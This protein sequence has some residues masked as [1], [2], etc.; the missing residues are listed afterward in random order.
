MKETMGDRLKRARIAAD[1]RSATKGAERVGV[2]ASTYR[3]H[4]NGQNE[5]GSDD[6]EVYGRA[7]GVRAGWLLTGEPPMERGAALSPSIKL[8][9]S[10]DPDDHTPGGDFDPSEHSGVSTDRVYQTDVEGASPVVDTRAGAGPGS[11]ALPAVTQSGGVIYSED[12]VLGEILLPGYLQR[13]LSA[14]PAGRIHWI[15][16][17]GDSMEPT[18]KGGDHIAVDTTDASIAQGGMFVARNGDGE[19]IVKRFFRIPKT[20]PAQIEIRS[21]NPLE[22]TR[23]VDA[24]WITIIGRVVAKIAR[25]G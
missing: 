18:L 9:S 3:A 5:F 17:R 11:V 16:V 10:F 7:F 15:R 12:A 8:F 25:I 21:D 24:D 2:A 13:E 14:A 19:I 6:A 23:T 22:P 20:D 1:F 4:E